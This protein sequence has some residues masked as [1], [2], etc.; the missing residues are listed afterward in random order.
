[1]IEKEIKTKDKCL[2]QITLQLL[3]IFLPI[4]LQVNLLSVFYSLYMKDIYT[5]SKVKLIPY[6]ISYIILPI[7]Y[8]WIR[9]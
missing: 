4:M 5:H 6:C 7:L 2:L 9:I 3:L 8:L 1:M